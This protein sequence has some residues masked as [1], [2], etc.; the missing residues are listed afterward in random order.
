MPN[1]HQNTTQKRLP[2]KPAK[3]LE[4]LAEKRG[5]TVSTMITIVVDDYL[6]AHGENR[7]LKDTQDLPEPRRALPAGVAV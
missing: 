4:A 5:L 7:I 6:R 2:I 3:Q 1:V